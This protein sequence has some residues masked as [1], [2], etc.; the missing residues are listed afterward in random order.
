MFFNTTKKIIFA[1][2]QSLIFALKQLTIG[3]EI[4]AVESTKIAL[5][6]AKKN[7]E[8]IEVG[9]EF[10]RQIGDNIFV[11]KHYTV[12]FDDNEALVFFKS[13]GIIGDITWLPTSC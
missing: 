12:V 11:E 1:D 5:I 9:V 7:K 2:N 8:G 6:S 10:D 4:K 3:K 13:H